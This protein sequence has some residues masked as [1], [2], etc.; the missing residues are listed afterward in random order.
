MPYTQ[1]ACAV[2]T[3]GHPCLRLARLPDYNT[4]PNKNY[5]VTMQDVR[6]AANASGVPFQYFQFDSW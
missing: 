3:R 2:L 6:H 1:H 4:E 5:E